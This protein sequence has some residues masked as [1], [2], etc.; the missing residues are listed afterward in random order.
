M[1]DKF[2]LA[3]GQETHRRFRLYLTVFRVSGI[4]V[5]FNKVPKLFN[6]YAAVA[7]FCSCVT[8][9]STVADIFMKIEDIERSMETVR[10][11]FPMALGV[12]MQIFLR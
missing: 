11:V 1:A 8:F 9:V 3:A 5:L 12:S 4:P 2:A 7:A 10:T 6:L